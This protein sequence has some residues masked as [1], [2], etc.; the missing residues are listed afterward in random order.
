MDSVTV[1]QKMAIKSS[2]HN[3]DRLSTNIANANSIGY[4]SISNQNGLASKAPSMIKR[5]ANEHDITAIG[6]NYISVSD[7][8]ETN[9][10]KSVNLAKD[11]TGFLRTTK[12]F[13]V[14]EQGQRIQF[15]SEAWT[16]N[17]N[18]EV[19]VDGNVIASLDIFESV[20]SSPLIYVADGV[21]T[22]DVMLSESVPKVMVGYRE[23]SNVNV[24]SELLEI[25]NVQNQY[26]SQSVL[27]KTYNEMMDYSINL[28]K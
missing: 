28:I 25:M 24:S 12:G 7:G 27:V 6:N 19:I 22:G 21:Y 10:T 17:K 18:A 5:T 26:K 23:M 4:K 13:F 2:I 8:S 15:E 14:T 20:N 9:F 16:I 3:L 11:S 1:I